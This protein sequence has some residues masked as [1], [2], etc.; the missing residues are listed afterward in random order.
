VIVVTFS[1]VQ[2]IDKMRLQHNTPQ[3]LIHNVDLSWFL[4]RRGSVINIETS[5]EERGRRC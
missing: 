4:S 5:W 3:R 1:N 2:F